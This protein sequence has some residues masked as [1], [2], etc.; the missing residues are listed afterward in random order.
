MDISSL[1]L[2]ASVVAA[3]ELT[4]T[5]DFMLALLRHLHPDLSFF[6]W[7]PFDQTSEPLASGPFVI[8]RREPSMSSMNYDERFVDLASVSIQV[9]VKDPEAD[10]KGA[11][12]SEAI[13]SSLH[14]EVRWPTYYPGLGSLVS[15]RRAEEA[16]RKT[17]WASGTGPVQFAD[18]PTGFIRYEAVYSVQIR[19]PLWG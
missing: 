14:K 18:L 8:V 13:R 3:Q 6:S 10:L 4:P 17:D 16:I 2:P 1:N 7:I 11:L 9:F 19:R 5:E 12:I 15:V